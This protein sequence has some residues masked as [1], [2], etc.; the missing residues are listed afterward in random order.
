MKNLWIILVLFSIQVQA[1]EKA[2]S[3]PHTFEVGLYNSLTLNRSTEVTYQNSLSILGK[4]N[5]LVNV[6]SFQFGIGVDGGTLLTGY[7][8]ISP[9]AIV[10]IKFPLQK[11]YLYAGC[12]AGYMHTWDRYPLSL[13]NKVV[14]G[15]VTGLHGGY[16]QP[17]AKHWSLTAE[18]GIRFIRLHWVE[19]GFSNFIKNTFRFLHITEKALMLPV[20]LGIRYS[21]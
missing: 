3:H 8:F 2:V 17:F 21:F 11:T 20:S 19:Y 10:N 13:E 5:G 1:Q 14:Q 15:Y 4:V 18:L 7:W 9:A 12:E 16:V 6:G